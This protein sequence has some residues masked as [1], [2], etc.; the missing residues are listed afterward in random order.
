[1]FKPPLVVT[2]C[3]LRSAAPPIV[4]EY[5]ATSPAA[6]GRDCCAPATDAAARPSAV[7]KRIPDERISFP[8]IWCGVMTTANSLRLR[9]MPQALN[10]FDRR[11]ERR[12][13]VF[14]QVRLGQGDNFVRYY[15]GSLDSS[16]ARI[17]EI[18]H[19]VNE[20]IS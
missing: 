1:M 8:G 16:P 18:S 9:R 15:T 12:I 2:C 3:A 19:C 4:C 14:R 17:G 11:F 6:G 5:F 10:P 13:D 20:Y 7:T